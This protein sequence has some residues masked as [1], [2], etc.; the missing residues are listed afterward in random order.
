LT[1]VLDGAGRWRLVGHGAKLYVRWV[2]PRFGLGW[3]EVGQVQWAFRAF[4]WGLYELLL[5]F[6]AEGRRTGVEPV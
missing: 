5:G 3:V 1:L 2:H 4:L 6:T